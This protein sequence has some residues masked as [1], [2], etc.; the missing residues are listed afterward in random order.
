[1]EFK[2][3]NS[4]SNTRQLNGW[5]YNNEKIFNSLTWKEKEAINLLIIEQFKFFKKHQRLSFNKL[6]NLVKKNKTVIHLTDKMIDDVQ[7]ELLWKEVIALNNVST[8]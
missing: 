5:N 7:L 3:S 6:V 8:S 2:L 1:M 4:V